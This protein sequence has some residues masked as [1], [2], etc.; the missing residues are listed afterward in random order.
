MLIDTTQIDHLRVNFASN[1][2]TENNTIIATNEINDII[3]KYPKAMTTQIRQWLTEQQ[4][5]RV[6]A[7]L[8]TVDTSKSIDDFDEYLKEVEENIR[9]YE[10]NEP[11]EIKLKVN[12]SFNEFP[13]IY[14]LFFLYR[15]FFNKLKNDQI[16]QR[17]SIMK[18]KN[19]LKVFN[20]DFYIYKND[21]KL[22][23]IIPINQRLILNKLL[24]IQIY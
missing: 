8:A 21:L 4:K 24:K 20:N 17:I 9:Q 22:F 23:K 10:Q 2:N 1:F 18:I 15:K 16:Y 7:P 13:I 19:V 14:L 3:D 5:N 6:T 12:K 11:N